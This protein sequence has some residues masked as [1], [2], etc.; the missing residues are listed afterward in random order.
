[1]ATN[2]FS[3]ATSEL[4]DYIAKNARNVSGVKVGDGTKDGDGIYNGDGSINN[5]HAPSCKLL[6]FK[7][8]QFV[9]DERKW[10][11]IRY[12][13]KSGTKYGERA[14]SNRAAADPNRFKKLKEQNQK[15]KRKIKSLNISNNSEDDTDKEQLDAGFQ[16]G[17]KASKNKTMIN[18]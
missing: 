14:N 15:Y 17:G 11:G 13:R 3:T 9:I 18:I 10:L 4:P 8:Q 5:G 16:F 1:M 12:K 2:N 6:P 7:Y